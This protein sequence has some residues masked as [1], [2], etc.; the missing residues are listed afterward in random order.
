MEHDSSS[1]ETRESVRERCE[2]SRD[3]TLLNRTRHCKTWI[4]ILDKYLEVWDKS[5]DPSDQVVS[6]LQTRLSAIR[7][8]KRL[9]E[10]R[11]E[12]VILLL[13][14]SGGESSY[15][16][17]SYQM[18]CIRRLLRP[19]CTVPGTTRGIPAGEADIVVNVQPAGPVSGSPRF[20]S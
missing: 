5:F 16:S 19:C 14:I 12:V 3:I 20:H 2:V 10:I 6:G 8:R 15:T 11:D 9:V 4:E 7:A 13:G 18:P 1:K 17:T